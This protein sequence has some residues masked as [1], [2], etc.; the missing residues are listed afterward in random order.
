MLYFY[1]SS[2]K[3]EI[4]RSFLDKGVADIVKIKQVLK[5]ESVK[6]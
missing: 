4:K 2:Y 3:F 5:Q 1:Y 6:A